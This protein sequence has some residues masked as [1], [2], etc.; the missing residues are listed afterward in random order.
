MRRTGC[1]SSL[2]GVEN[3]A[4][5]RVKAIAQIV[6]KRYLHQTRQR[7][8]G[9][10]TAK[11]T[12]SP[13]TSDQSCD[14]AKVL[15]LGMSVIINQRS[16]S[17]ARTQ[18]SQLSPS[19]CNLDRSPQWSCSSDRRCMIS[20]PT[21]PENSIT[22]AQK[23]NQGRKDSRCSEDA[24][25]SLASRRS[26]SEDLEDRIASP[27]VHIW[28]HDDTSCEV[29]MPFCPVSQV[30]AIWAA[31]AERSKVYSVSSAGLPLG[32]QTL[33]LISFDPA[34]RFPEL[35]SLR[36]VERP[37]ASQSML[38]TQVPRPRSPKSPLM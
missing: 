26:I 34:I 27:G 32:H 5:V 14:H 31:S 37:A 15:T 10:K 19:V 2:K 35:T 38:S 17:A 9:T 3:G 7:R 18:T 25:S 33:I 23:S 12:A 36:T 20:R 29:Q 16:E 21:T 8:K 11:E 30:G 6:L 4:V 13:M 24:F 1:M 22:K 28:P